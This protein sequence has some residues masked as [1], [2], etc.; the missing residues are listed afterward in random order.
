MTTGYLDYENFIDDFKF[1]FDDAAKKQQISAFFESEQ[2]LRN[3]RV[4]KWWE[5][6]KGK[7]NINGVLGDELAFLVG[8]DN[9]YITKIL[10][11]EFLTSG[12]KVSFTEDDIS[13]F[14]LEIY[15]EREAR[16]KKGGGGRY[17]QRI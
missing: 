9:E 16:G 3:G 7:T 6:M 11:G 12:N 13:K 5:D 1:D 2:A 4:D 17:T 8:E 14:I 10:T 15:K